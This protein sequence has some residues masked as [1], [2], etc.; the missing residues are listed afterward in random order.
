MIHLCWCSFM[1]AFLLVC[2]LRWFRLLCV[3]SPLFCRPP[4]VLVVLLLGVS[5]SCCFPSLLSAL[6]A[7]FV[8]SCLLRAQNS[9]RKSASFFMS[10]EGLRRHEIKLPVVADSRLGFWCL[11]RALLFVLRCSVCFCFLL[12]SIGSIWLAYLLV[13]DMRTATF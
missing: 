6:F 8:V 2:L 9:R 4:L 1:V 11:L 10:P 12:A 13:H 5:S 7:C 3:C